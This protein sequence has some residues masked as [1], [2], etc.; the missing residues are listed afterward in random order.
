MNVRVLSGINGEADYA[1]Q[2]PSN[3]YNF[4]KKVP[5]GCPT[6]VAGLFKKKDK[7]YTQTAEFKLKR[8]AMALSRGAFLTLVRFNVLGLGTALKKRDSQ[9]PSGYEPLV[10]QW[11]HLGGYYDKLRDAFNAGSKKRPIFRNL[12]AR[13]GISGIHMVPTG[14]NGLTLA[15]VGAFIS[16]AY[17]VLVVIIPL[18]KL[19]IP[20]KEKSD[21]SG[22]S[23]G[24]T[25]VDFPSTV[26][27]DNAP[28][29]SSVPPIL[30][31]GAAAGLAFMLFKK[32]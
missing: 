25:I 26:T 8:G 23:T 20:E 30:L 12:G 2:F 3:P 1:A 21:D 7:P 9:G 4:G 29:K 17:P 14:V 10:W 6:P 31:V 28:E 19:F 22:G 16:E 32:K 13:F 27:A 24:Y 18:I 5:V 11:E 15:A